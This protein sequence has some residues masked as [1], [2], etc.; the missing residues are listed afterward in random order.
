VVTWWGAW[1]KASNLERGWLVKALKRDDVA[2]GD[3]AIEFF[4]ESDQ[5]VATGSGSFSGQLAS[6]YTT[7]LANTLQQNA[8]DWIGFLANSVNDLSVAD[9]ILVKQAVEEGA[10][11]LSGLFGAAQ[12]KGPTALVDPTDPVPILTVTI[13]SA[14]YNIDLRPILS[15]LDT[16]SWTQTTG[17]GKNASITTHIREFYTDADAPQ[18][19]DSGWS[20]ADPDDGDATVSITGTA[21]EGEELTANFADD[22][23]DGAATGVTYQW[24]RDGVDI[25]L[26]TGSS[27]TLTSD[28]VGA[29]ITVE[30]DYTDGQ[31]FTESIESAATAPVNAT[32]IAKNDV[33]AL[34]NTTLASGLIAPLWFTHNDTDADLDTLSITAINGVSVDGAI[35]STGL[36]ADF[37]AGVLVGISGTAALTGSPFT[38][39]YTVSD[40]TATA[41]GSVTLS[42]HDVTSGSPNDDI[43]LNGNDFSYIDGQDGNDGITGDADLVL[44]GNAGIDTF[45]GGVGTDTLS[46]GAAEDTLSGGDGTD[47]LNGGEGADLLV[48]G[49]GND[50]INTGVAD[51]NIQDIVRFTATTEFVDTVSNFD[52]NGATSTD[53]QIQFS[54]ALATLLDDGTVNGALD[55]NSAN[56]SGNGSNQAVDLGT[57][58]ALILD[59]STNDGVA[60]ASLSTANSVRDEFNAE[61][62]ITAAVGETTLLVINDNSAGGNSFAL[63]LYTENNGGADIVTTAGAAD[64]LTL[65]GTFSGNG[66]L[67]PGNFELL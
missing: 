13:G 10:F 43:L 32:P 67:D 38:F 17:S 27:Y 22:D 9:A 18:G 47:T 35:G 53:D 6:S 57:I 34:S 41:T 29:T 46:G 30:V 56:D 14:T 61:F 4:T 49:G 11:A 42:V 44:D 7:A 62:A 19:Y 5:F 64:T 58:E 12:N 55:F 39:S 3:M 28:D 31:G 52:V 15:D 65:I 63:W 54:G 48:G 20:T 60:T 1:G 21:S 51:D 8:A 16:E 2:G 36:I 33:W 59:G 24:Q 66:A 50:T 23:P 26:A 37:Q 25:G 45:I 40:G